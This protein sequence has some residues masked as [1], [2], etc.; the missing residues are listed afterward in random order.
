MSIW[1][2]PL[3]LAE[4]NRLGGG[5]LIEHAGITFTEI[6]ADYLCASMPVD[7]RTRQPYGLLHGGASV[8]LAETLGSMGANMCVDSTRLMC[9]GQEI[10]ANHVRAVREG[11]VKGTARPWH[12][13]GRSQVWSIDIVDQSGALVCIS[14]LTMAVIATPQSAP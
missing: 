4:L 1:R 8:V 5:S 12:I 11:M 2:S 3:T 7:A 9:V 14:R 10:N 13:G 6:G